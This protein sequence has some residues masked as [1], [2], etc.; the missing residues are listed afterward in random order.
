MDWTNLSVGVA[1]IL[2]LIYVVREIRGMV[3]D[4]NHALVG[5]YAVQREI[6]VALGV[7]SEK[8]DRL[9]DDNSTRDVILT[10]LHDDNIEAAILL[11]SSDLKLALVLKNADASTAS[12][13]KASDAVTAA[14]LKT[15]DENKVRKVEEQGPKE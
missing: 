8:T 9:H 13:L 14:V 7:L 4:N 1:A 2:G 3:K 10:S 11:K 5:Q 12:I 15:A 6:S